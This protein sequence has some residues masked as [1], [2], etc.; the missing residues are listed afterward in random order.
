MV[1]RLLFILLLLFCLSGRGFCAE[2]IMTE[3]QLSRLETNLMQLSKIN[4]KLE[5]QLRTL[6]NQ[7]QMQEELLATANLSLEQ[8]AKTQR[9]KLR[10]LK[11]QRNL[12]LVGAL[13]VAIAR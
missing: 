12:L 7:L 8:Y 2:Y 11:L 6:H 9:D 5:E 1:R 3:P 10:E 13:V 4:S